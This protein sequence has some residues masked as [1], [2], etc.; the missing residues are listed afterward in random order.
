MKLK[1]LLQYKYAAEIK[2][3]QAA[4]L[5]NAVKDKANFSIGIQN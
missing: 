4:P 2:R 5:L 1:T 3:K